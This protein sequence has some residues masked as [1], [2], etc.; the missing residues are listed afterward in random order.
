[1]EKRQQHFSIGYLIVAVGAIF[2][3]QYFLLQQEAETL[4]Y[5]RFKTLVKK[6]LVSNLVI[7]EKTIRGEIVAGG[8]K[9]AVSAERYGALAHGGQSPADPR[10]ISAAP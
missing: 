3:L 10:M 2:A 9:E 6:G 5:S 4:D 7:G 1:M 8:V